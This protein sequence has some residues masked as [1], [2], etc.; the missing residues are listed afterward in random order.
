MKDDFQKNDNKINNSAQNIFN[1]VE[2][3]TISDR[4]INTNRNK[5]INKH[6]YEAS[7]D[8]FLI[9]NLIKIYPSDFDS[10]DDSLK[11]K[12]NIIT[13]KIDSITNKPIF[14]FFKE[15]DNNKQILFLNCIKEKNK[16]LIYEKNKSDFILQIT[17]N[18]FATKFE[19]YDQIHK[20]LVLEI[21]YDIN[22]MGINGP[23]KMKI[24]LAKDPFSLNNSN[25]NLKNIKNSDKIF[26]LKNKNPIFDECKIFYNYFLI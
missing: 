19:V 6:S 9:Q 8:I 25:K 4:K 7:N 22:L 15:L 5:K 18:F 1:L 23:P 2:K 10:M 14:S 12:K 13:K 11:W 24:I 16:Y 17:W 3:N 20:N 21:F 26:V